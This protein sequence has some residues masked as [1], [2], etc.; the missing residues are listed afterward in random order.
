MASPPFNKPTINQLKALIDTVLGT[1]SSQSTVNLNRNTV[2]AAYAGYVFGLILQAVDQIADKNTVKLT[3]ALATS[4]N[5]TPKIFVMRGAPGPSNSKAQDFGFAVFKYKGIS[6]EIHMGVQ[7]QGSSGVLHEFDIS[8]LPTVEAQKCRSK[9]KNKNAAPGAGAASAIF[10]C[11]CY[12]GYLGIELGRE[13]VGLKSDFTSVPMSRL[14]TNA[15][16]EVVAQFLKKNYRPK[17][18]SRL[19]P[20]NPNIEQRFVSAVADELTNSL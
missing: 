19:D 4:Q 20:G 7:Y 11:K 12:S 9:S 17:I 18:S 13:F 3:S 1:V 15:D 2:D 8:I 5:A 14:V 10:E 16:S 6:H